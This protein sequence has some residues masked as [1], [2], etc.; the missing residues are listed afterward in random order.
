M[1]GGGGTSDVARYDRD[2][3]PDGAF[4]NLSAVNATHNFEGVLE[5]VG[6]GQAID[7]WNDLDTLID[8]ENVRGTP[9]DDIIIGS[10]GANDLRGRNGNDLI[11]G[12]G[13]DDTLRGE[14]GSDILVDGTGNNTFNL[15]ESV[16]AQDTVRIDAG[17]FGAG[18]VADFVI[19]FDAG[20]TSTDDLLDLTLLLDGG[21]N[22]SSEAD[23]I[24]AVDFGDGNAVINVDGDGVGTGQSFVTVATLQGV[25]LGSEITYIYNGTQSDTITVQPASKSKA[26]WQVIR[27]TP[28][29]VARRSA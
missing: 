23:Y 15:N 29:A 13:G 24:Q 26:T 9:Y 14:E 7:S 5:T 28:P 12:G 11:E 17:A 21:F 25:G 19:G 10:S 4:V 18:D 3:G 20:T 2:N 8:V 22:P 1:N 27:Q 6:P 16:A